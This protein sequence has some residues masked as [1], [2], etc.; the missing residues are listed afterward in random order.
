MERCE[1]CDRDIPDDL[2]S[3]HHL[4]PK[5]KGGKETQPLHQICHSKIHSLFSEGELAHVYD[6]IEKLKA[7]EEIE[8]F[9]NWIRKKPIDY[10]DTNLMSNDLKRKKKR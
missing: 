2:K 9:I 5:S 10:R 7:N 1:L 3:R 6:T 8:R 4:I